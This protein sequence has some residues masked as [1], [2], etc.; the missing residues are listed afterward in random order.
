MKHNGI[1]NACTKACTKHGC[2]HLRW[3]CCLFAY[4]QSCAVFSKA[5]CP[6]VIKTKP[7]FISVSN[8]H[9][10]IADQ[11]NSR[12]FKGWFRKLCGSFFCNHLFR[13]LT[14]Q[15]VLFYAKNVPVSPVYL[16][17]FYW[18]Q[19]QHVAHKRVTHKINI[20]HL[21]WRDFI[22]INRI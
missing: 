19:L 14:P 2:M 15:S 11:R 9:E 22:I 3:I 8:L 4:W 6:K 5:M 21:P 10:I 13:F 17:L 18:R 12:E 1:A 20:L 16:H 7:A